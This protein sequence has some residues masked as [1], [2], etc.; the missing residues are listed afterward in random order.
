M[1]PRQ[2]AVAPAEPTGEL[3]VSEHDGK[4]AGM[5]AVTS[6]VSVTLHQAGLKHTLPLL[7]RLNQH[8]G[9]DCPSCAW[10]DPKDRSIAEFCENGAKAV[11]EAATTA[12]LTPEW[13]STQSLDQLAVRGDQ[14]FNE[15]G[16][17]TAPA[18][19]R[20]GRDRYEPVSWDEA[21]TV[22]GER[23]AALRDPNRAAFYTSGRASNEAA[24]LYQLFVR[25]LGTNNLPDCS[26][27]CH[28]SS[29]VALSPTIGVGKGTVTLED[30]EAADLV[31]VIGQNPGTNAPRMLTALQRVA[32]RGGTIVSINPMR[33][34]GLVSVRNPQDF[35]KPWRWN[36][37]IR[38]QS[39]ASLFLPV[40][41]GG[42]L[43][44]LLGVQK[45]LLGLERSGTPAIDHAFVDAHTSGF[46]D[47]EAAVDA[48][49]W[50][51]VLAV[52]GVAREAIEELAG[53][54]A[55]NTKI[56]W[57]WA[58][59]ITQH[60]RAVD[61]IRQMVNLALMR[62]AIGKEGAGLCPVRGHS[63]VQGDRTVGIYDK[64]TAAFLDRLGDAVGF[65]PPRRHG[66][67][68]VE[69]IEAMHRG[70]I[71]VFVALGGNMM[72]ASPDTSFTADAFTR[73]GLNVSIVT[74]LNRS[75]V[76]VGDE[77]ILLPCLARTDAD[78]TGGVEQFVTTENSMGIVTRSRGRL[79][80]PSAEVRSEPAIVAGIASATLGDR[81]VV[82]WEHLIGDYDRIRDLI[83]RVVPG[84]DDYNERVRR[85]NG[86]ELPNAARRGDFSALP[87]ARAV[88]TPAR[89]DVRNSLPGDALTLTTI[90]SH[91]QFNTT[92][93]GA[94][95]RYRG[96]QGDRRVVFVNADDA[97]DRRL[98]AGQ[99]V[100]I[101]GVDDD[102]ARC[103]ERFSVVLYDLPRG[104]C[105]AYFPEANVVVPIHRTAAG[106]N[107]PVSKAVPVR[108]TPA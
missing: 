16:R 77:A 71:D 48:C 96:I 34:Q 69:T 29:G 54:L 5:R 53:L 4:A 81:S 63:N 61:T 80:P 106:S 30:I 65:E 8:D 40:R 23:L 12:R 51:D 17:L 108:L 50:D 67:D 24:F 36:H 10:P 56:V 101:V 28:E 57:C 83:E 46:A 2:R 98:E 45:A 78:G 21:L 85:P 27:M 44:L 73:V 102:G 33:E 13:L 97:R 90:R 9:F 58:M 95:D 76:V 20:S 86:I 31:I 14:W 55:A 26:N 52:S 104:S 60:E 6:A 35:T 66:F 19:K 37:A 43:A 91:D 11:A 59:G 105:A 75:H 92:V 94:D 103:A 84:F 42:D 32:E 68:V 38:G 99:L 25:E 87:D 1:E 47:V 70:D 72:S 74:K 88:L 41:V 22:V 7:A 64:P 93:Y 18:I 62:G 39:L 49:A 82:D 15:A 89:L 100:D 79:D 3:K 107:T